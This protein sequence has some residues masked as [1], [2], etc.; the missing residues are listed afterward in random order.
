MIK[1]IELKTALNALDAVSP[2]RTTMPILKNLMLKSTSGKLRITASSIDTD[3][4][5]TVNNEGEDLDVCIPSTE[6]KLIMQ[7]VQEQSI[8]LS[9][10]KTHVYLYDGEHKTKF[11][12]LPTEDFPLTR[13]GEVDFYIDGKLLQSILTKT[14]VSCSNDESHAVL[15]GINLLSN[16]GVLTAQSADGFRASYIK[17]LMGTE[18]FN[19]IIPRPDKRIIKLFEGKIGVCVSETRLSFIG[20]GFTY[21]TALIAG[22]FPR[23]NSIIPATHK[24]EIV[25]EK[26]KLSNAVKRAMVFAKNTHNIVRFEVKDCQLNVY[27][28]DDTGEN[29]MQFNI[30]QIGDDI[31]IGVNG[32]YVNEFLPLASDKIIMR[33]TD[34]KAPLTMRIPDNETFTYM[35]MPM[36]L[37]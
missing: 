32:H 15:T 7:T 9:Q 20:E 26:K 5:L 33:F 34:P 30:E 19:V 2:K 1:T 18:D 35:L 31:E 4:T 6:F 16:D 27:S 23:I 29:S 25:I 14:E 10:K 36:H 12:Y 24:T 8:K 13:S 21:N 11:K 37:K 28:M 17:M 3:L 22:N